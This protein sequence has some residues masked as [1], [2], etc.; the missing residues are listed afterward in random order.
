MVVIL[1]IAGAIVVPHMLRGGQLGLQAAS[2]M[3]IADIP[4]AQ[5]EAI[6][7]QTVR[8]VVFDLQNNA[9]RITDGADTTLSASWKAGAGQNYVIDFDEDQKFTGVSLA[10]A[11]F[12]G[13]STLEFDALGSAANAGTANLATNTFRYRITVTPFT[14]QVTV[15]EVTG[16]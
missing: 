5:N 1:G 6:A 4:Y 11:D 9:Y 3:V 8:R 2:R 12:G 14:G 10:S 15:A 13:T 7:H 16:E